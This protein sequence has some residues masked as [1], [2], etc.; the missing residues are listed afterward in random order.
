MSGGGGEGGSGRQRE[1][2]S[3]CLNPQFHGYVRIERS[4]TRLD[5]FRDIFLARHAKPSGVAKSTGNRDRVGITGSPGGF[6]TYA[7]YVCTVC[8]CVCVHA[9]EDIPR[10]SARVSVKRLVCQIEH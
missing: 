3:P 8:V 2:R 9:H 6:R 5:R 10:V 1:S 4:V 7:A